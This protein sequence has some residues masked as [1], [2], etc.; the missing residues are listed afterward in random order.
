LPSEPD[1]GGNVTDTSI[2]TLSHD[3]TVA[4]PLP[5]WRWPTCAPD[6]T[7]VHVTVP[8]TF[9]IAASAACAASRHTTTASGATS[10][11]IV[12]LLPQ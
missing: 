11:R 5:H 3:G 8:K 2:G 9:G 6:A 1:A 7:V 4:V 12:L 10:L